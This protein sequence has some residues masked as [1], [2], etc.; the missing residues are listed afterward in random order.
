MVVVTHEINF[1][2]EAADR[3]VFMDQGFVVE[4]GTPQHV[5]MA[6]QHARTRAFHLISMQ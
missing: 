2:R 4:S 5:L 6:P 3:V 1:A